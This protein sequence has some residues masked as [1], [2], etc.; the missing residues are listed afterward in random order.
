M[1]LSSSRLATGEPPGSCATGGT[2][3]VEALWVGDDWQVVIVEG[4]Q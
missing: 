4:R 3:A 2:I 1:G